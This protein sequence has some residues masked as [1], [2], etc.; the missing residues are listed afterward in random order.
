MD[1]Q[2]LGAYRQLLASSS[3]PWASGMVIHG[4]NVLADLVAGLRRHLETDWTATYSRRLEPRPAVIGCVPWLTDRDVA[5][6][7]TAFDQSCIIVDKQ[8]PEFGAVKRLAVRGRP[9][10]STY[11]EGFD[12]L[13]VADEEGNAPVVGPYDGLPDP[14]DLGPIRVV[15]WQKAVDGSARP[16]LHSKLL[17]VGV[18]TY[19][20]DDEMFAGHIPTFRPLATWMGSANWTYASRQQIEFGLWSHDQQ[21]VDRNYRYLLSLLA[22]SEPRGAS[23]V[24][25]EPNLVS[26]V[27]D[28]DGFREYLAEHPDRF[29]DDDE[30]PEEDPG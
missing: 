14:T 13:S 30:E 1:M 3:S 9:I 8:Q 17:V 4:S 21:L 24:G 12:E 18:T 27:W 11:L 10:S 5:D 15:G 16:M 25:P 6:A 7:L 28:D 26:V 23:T 2:P 20:E 22:F 19:Y 29:G